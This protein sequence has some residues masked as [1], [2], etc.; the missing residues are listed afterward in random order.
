MI[1][2]TANFITLIKVPRGRIFASARSTNDHRVKESHSRVLRFFSLE[3][4][5]IPILRVGNTPL[6]RIKIL[7][8]YSGGEDSKFLWKENV[9]KC[10]YVVGIQLLQNVIELSKFWYLFDVCDLWTSLVLNRIAIKEKQVRRK[11]NDT[12][13]ASFIAVVS[14]QEIRSYL[15]KF[16]RIYIHYI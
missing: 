8:I 13:I 5:W 15:N 11:N 12:I 6:R 1:P 2:F 3:R 9:W 16:R 14:Q 7:T 4:W 10:M